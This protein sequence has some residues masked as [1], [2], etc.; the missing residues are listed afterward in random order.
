M[1]KPTLTDE[2]RRQFRMDPQHILQFNC[3]PG[4]ACFT[5]CC[6]DVTIVL[7]PYD[8]LRLKNALGISSG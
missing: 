2:A 1:S 4:V 5:Q 3:T 7:T 8:V 6:Q